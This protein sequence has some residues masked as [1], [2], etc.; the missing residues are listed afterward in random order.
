MAVGKERILNLN[1]SEPED[2]ILWEVLAVKPE[3]DIKICFVG[4]NS[5]HRQ[6]IR[7]AVEDSGHISLN[8]NVSRGFQLWFDTA[9]SEIILHCHSTTGK[10][11]IYNIYDAGSGVKSQQHT[12]GMI[13]R[14]YGRISYYHCNDY[15]FGGD[16][17]KLVFSVELV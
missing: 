9:P 3:Q 5:P 7:I 1:F 10:V 6:G 16:F 4:K 12:S 17:D 2:V 14:K 15:G 13:L 11:S 8:D